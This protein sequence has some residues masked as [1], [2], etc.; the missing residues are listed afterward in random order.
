[1]QYYPHDYQTYAKDFI[2]AHPSVGLLLDMGLGK[3][4]IVLTALWELILDYFEIG[5]V[6]VVAPIR[7]AKDTWPREIE[8][9]DH[10]KDLT[11]SVV[12]GTEKERRA[13]LNKPASIYICNREVVSWIV[14]NGLFRFDCLCIDELSSFKSHSTKRFRSLKKVRGQCRRIIGM[15]GTPGDLL[16]L[17]SQIYLLDGGVRLERFITAYRD[18][19]F[20]PD[21]RNREVIFSYKPKEGAEE[22]IYKAISDICISMKAGD[23][24]KLPDQV[25]SNVEVV[26]DEKEQAMYDRL[27]SDYILPFPDG[28]IDAASAVGISNKLLQ[29][30]GGAV[31]DENGKVRH[32]HDR[33]LDAL[34]DLIEMANGEPVLVAVWFKHEMERV[35]SR[36]GAVPIDKS[37]DIKRW[38]RGEIPVAVIHPASAGHGLNLYEGGHHLIWLGLTYSLELYLQCNARLTRLG[39]KDTVTIQHI[40]TKGTIDEDVLKALETKDVSQE[41]LMAAVKARIGGK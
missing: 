16:S 12:V 25:M 40:I 30:A 18:R 4:V 37:E 21:K 34:E 36:F 19:Y 41:A 39:Q 24:I 28:D 31:Y 38:N 20:L 13:A 23:Y 17:W 14:D 27:A 22:A 9:W 5:R 15:T 11:Y 3:T 6:L 33:K 8:K 1:M 26:M 32:I 7:V 10:L 2:I 29:M 35:I